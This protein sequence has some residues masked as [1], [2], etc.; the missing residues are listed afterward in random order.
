MDRHEHW[1]TVYRSKGDAELSWFQAQPAVSLSLISGIQPLPRSVIDIGGG[2]SGLAGK[3]LDEGIE[4]TTVVDI[5]ESAIERG[6]KRLGEWAGRVRWVVADVL[7]LPPLGEFEVWHDRAVFH[8]LTDPEDRR[9]YIDAAVRTLAPGGHAIVATF[10]LTGPEKCSGLPV[11]RYEAGGLAR[12]L[13]PSFSLVKS[14]RE[15]HTTPWG[16][17]QDFTYVVLRRE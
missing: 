9:R 5:S 6:K 7:A 1:E 16:K 10:A 4:S 2:Q 14:E 15:T 3:L 11:A 13:G 12:E 17:V 8:F